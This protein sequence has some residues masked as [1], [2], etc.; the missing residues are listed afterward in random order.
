[1]ATDCRRLTTPPKPAFYNDPR[2]RSVVY[3]VA[4]RC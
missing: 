3:Q 2:V 1:M 4:V